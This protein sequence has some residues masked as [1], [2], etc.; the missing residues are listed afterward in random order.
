MNEG[1]VLAIRLVGDPILN[2]KARGLDLVRIKKWKIQK[3]V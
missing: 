3:Y 1:K 2:K